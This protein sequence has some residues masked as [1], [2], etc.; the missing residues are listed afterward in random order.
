MMAGGCT[1]PVGFD[2]EAVR[3]RAGSLR[4][5]LWKDAEISARLALRIDEVVFSDVPALIAEVE[6]L[7]WVE[8]EALRTLTELKKTT[9]LDGE[10]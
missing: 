7:R 3:S 9:T 8:R 5:S 1:A 2:L 4:G 10:G 6:R